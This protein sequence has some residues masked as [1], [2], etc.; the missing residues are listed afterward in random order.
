MAV[1]A[2]APG[3]LA[4]NVVVFARVLR[5]S[6]LPVGPDRAIAAVRALDA[7]GFARREDVHAALA[8]TL[9]GRREDLA[10]FDAA[11][12]AF[13]RDPKLVE[14]MMAALLPKISG[15]GRPP[16]DAKRPARLQQALAGRP[17]PPEPPKDTGGDEHTIDALMTWSERER[18]K[19]RDFDSMTVEEFR[20]ACRLVRELP[21]PVDPVPVRRWRTSRRGP[22]DLGA[23]LRRMARDPGLANLL[24]RERRQRPAPLV[25]LCDVSGSMD[26]Y[27]RVMLHY[28]HAL[29]RER[30][31]VS[32]FTFG[33]RLTNV[34]RAMRKRDPDEAMAAAAL[35][36]EDWS[37]GTR[38][39]PSLDEFNR[40]WA[41]RVLT[42]NA[43]VLLVTDGL[44]RADDGSLGDAAATLARFARRIV[45][46]NP[47]LRWDGFEPR[48]AGVRALL[49]HVDRHVP[50]HSLERLRDLGRALAEA[51]Q[52]R[53]RWRPAAGS[54]TI[55]Q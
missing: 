21:A 50:V 16:A 11:F 31:R 38:I 40:H 49:P 46:L 19:A 2:A 13:W 32:V 8:A 55:R 23:T 36:V 22:M 4:R 3:S 34:T 45:W 27:A 29:M 52:A 54:T 30:P 44:D 42:G 33:T 41:R 12:D 43:A 14:Q 10:L 47:L 51:G 48:A 6:G 18:L 20:E 15:R 53:P 24:R 25:V 26:R 28:A 9:I 17:P 1:L 7:V 39:G 5:A 35:A 37:G